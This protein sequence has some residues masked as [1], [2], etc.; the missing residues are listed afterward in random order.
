MAIE[1][2]YAEEPLSPRFRKFRVCPKGAAALTIRAI[3]IEAPT[4]EIR[5][6]VMDNLFGAGQSGLKIVLFVMVVLCL[7]ALAFWLLR[8]FGGGRLGSDAT[9]GRQLRLAVIDQATIDSAQLLALP[10]GVEP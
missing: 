5:G 10:K 7:L 3:P 2:R 6:G 8:R 9:R 1:Y 4:R